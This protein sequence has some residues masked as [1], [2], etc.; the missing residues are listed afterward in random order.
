MERV[1]SDSTKG[2][3][4]KLQKQVKYLM[5]IEQLFTLTI[6]KQKKD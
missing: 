2:K 4:M 5:S 6:L 1:E 3:E